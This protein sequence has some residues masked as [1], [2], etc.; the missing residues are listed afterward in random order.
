M[1]VLTYGFNVAILI[2]IGWLF[3]FGLGITDW[4]SMTIITICAFISSFLLEYFAGV[5]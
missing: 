2:L 1:N 5:R 3:I 4:F